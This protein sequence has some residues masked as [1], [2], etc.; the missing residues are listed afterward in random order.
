MSDIILT[1]RQQVRLQHTLKKIASAY[2][3]LTQEI[4]DLHD[5]IFIDGE[6]EGNNDTE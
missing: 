5:E 2:R 3:I 1:E 4:D 6:K